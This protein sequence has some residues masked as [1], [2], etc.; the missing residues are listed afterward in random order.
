VTPEQWAEVFRAGWSAIGGMNEPPGQALA[1]A[2]F[3]MEQKI[4]E[5]APADPDVIEP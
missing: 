1:S 2:L 5:F 4:R 3:A